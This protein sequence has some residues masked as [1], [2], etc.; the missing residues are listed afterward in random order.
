MPL[1][2]GLWLLPQIPFEALLSFHILN[3]SCVPSVVYKQINKQVQNDLSISIHNQINR[4][5]NDYEEQWFVD[6]FNTLQ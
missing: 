3:N 6:H 4:Q 2:T 5:N 1:F